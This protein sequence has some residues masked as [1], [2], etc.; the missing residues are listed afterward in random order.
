MV[1]GTKAETRSF[2]IKSTGRQKIL[3]CGT[4]FHSASHFTEGNKKDGKKK[5]HRR[6]DSDNYRASRP[7]KSSKS[8]IRRLKRQ[9]E[10]NFTTIEVNID[11]LGYEYSNLT[12][13]D[14]ED[15]IGNS[16]F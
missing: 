8:G 10:N 12:S 4:E 3:K 13:Y 6:G 1:I 14:S 11:K 7:I 5:H 9:T 16:N 15:S 2:I